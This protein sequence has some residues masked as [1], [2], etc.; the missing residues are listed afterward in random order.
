MEQRMNF[1]KLDAL[2]TERSTLRRLLSDR[3]RYRVT[4]QLDKLA[5]VEAEITELVL[6]PLNLHPRDIPGRW[7]VVE[8]VM[9]FQWL[10]SAMEYTENPSIIWAT[11]DGLIVRSV[12]TGGWH[13]DVKNRIIELTASL[14]GILLKLRSKEV[15]AAA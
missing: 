15:E 2:L 11:C 7:M 4:T 6:E 13:I 3:I 1:E 9:G 8:A 10:A 14:D 12:P 5:S